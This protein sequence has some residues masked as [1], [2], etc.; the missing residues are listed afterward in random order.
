MDLDHLFNTI[1]ATLPAVIAAVSSL[2]NGH[3]LKNHV[4]NNLRDGGVSRQAQ[5]GRRRER[6]SPKSRGAA[7]D[8]D[9]YKPPD[10]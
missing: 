9:W 6:K 4:V 3:V 8:S 7:P 5:D 1:I 10:V 2:R